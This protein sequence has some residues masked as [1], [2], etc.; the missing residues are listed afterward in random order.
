[1]HEDI[2]HLALG[3]D[4]APK[5]H[6]LAANR[7]EHLVQVPI[8]IGLT[9]HGAKAPRIARAEGHDPS[10]NRLVGHIDP[11]LGEQLLDIAVA[12][13][14]PEIDPDRVLDKCWIISAGKR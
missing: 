7:D 4:G 3:I 1:L 2:E 5:I 9:P 14:E 11:P 13:R 10:S 8:R 6:S 12:E